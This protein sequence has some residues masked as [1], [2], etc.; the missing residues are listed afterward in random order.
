MYEKN[1]IIQKPCFDTKKNPIMSRFLKYVRA[2]MRQESA[3]YIC[4][5]NT[6]HINAKPNV[7]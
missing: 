6:P 5:E 2:E 7:T 3:T 1:P 4:E